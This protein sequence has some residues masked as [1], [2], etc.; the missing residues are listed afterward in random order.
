MKK[1]VLALAF[2]MSSM[3][4]GQAYASSVNINKATVEQLQSVHGIGEKTA[5]AIVQYRKKHGAFKSIADL[6]NVSGIG[7]KKFAK[8]KKEVKVSGATSVSKDKKSKGN[9]KDGKDARAKESK[10]DSKSKVKSKD[11][12]KGK[13]KE[14]KSKDKKKKK[15]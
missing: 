14:K 3:L 15:S 11:K 8:M 7:D 12:K 6:K 10:K 5:K 13:K 4:V 2:L 9:K 1:I